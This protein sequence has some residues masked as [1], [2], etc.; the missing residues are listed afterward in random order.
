MN[1]IYKVIW[2][3]A[4][5]CFTAVGEYAK[6][7]GKSSKSS[8]SA[9]ATI[10][11]TENLSSTSAF[12][13]T[14]IGL[15]LMAAGFCIQASAIPNNGNS[16]N[17]NID[18]PFTHT[19]GLGEHTHTTNNSHKKE[20]DNSD[21]SIILEFEGDIGDP[22]ALK[23]GETLHI[24]GGETDA[25]NLSNN[26]NIG[27]VADGDILMI[28][29]AKDIDLDAD[30]SVTMGDTLVDN[31]G[32]TI[33]NTVPAKIVSLTSA[34]LNNGGNQITNVASGGLLT[35]PNN[36]HNAATIGDIVANQ[37]K[38]VSINST[39]GTNEDN[40]G[41]QGA[42]AIAIGKGASAVGQTTV[43]IGLNSGSG[44][45]AGTREG[46]SV[47][48]ASGQNV[49]S[50]GNVGIGRGAGSNIT[51]ITTSAINPFPVIKGQNVAIGADA[52][53][54]I[55]G[56][57]NSA[58]GERSGRVV[59]GNANTAI[60]SFSGNNVKGSANIAMGP[61]TGV[62]VSGDYN[63]AI[64]NFAGANVR[65]DRNVALGTEAG[66]NVSGIRNVAIGN[67]AGAG[68]TN[69]LTVA[70]GNNAGN[71]QN[72]QIGKNSISVGTNSSA[73]GHSSMALGRGSVSAGINAIGIGVQSIASATGT[74][75]VGDRAEA[76]GEN[77]IAI[78]KN[79]L[80]TGSQAIGVGSR[81]GNGGAAYGDNADAGG[82][83]MSATLTVIEGTAIG[84]GSIVNVNNGVALGSK[85]VANRTATGLGTVFVPT[86]ASGLA[87]ES[88]RSTVL[89]AV[90]VGNNADGN[91]QIVNVA[92]GRDDSDAVNVSQLR[93]LDTIV[94]GIDFPI[95]SSNAKPYTTSVTGTDALA[96][97]S[98]AIANGD[99]STAV[100]ENAK[101]IG[102]Q[103][104]AFGAGA[105]ATARSSLA[106]GFEAK[107][108]SGESVA[109]GVR[110]SAEGLGATAVGPTAN[111]RGEDSV[112]LGRRSKADGAG[113]MALGGFSEAV[114][115]NASAVGFNAEAT[116]K[117]ATAIG[118]NAKALG[119]R[120]VAI[121]EGAQATT[122]TGTA[123][124]SRTRA[125]GIQSTAVGVGSKATK[126]WSTAMGFVSEAN[127]LSSVALGDRSIVGGKESI[128]IGK[129]NTV[130]GANSIAVGTGH[131]VS[132]NNSGA[133]GDPN[134][135]SG[136]GSY[137]VGNNNAIAANN[138]FVLG[139]NV[140]IKASDKNSIALGEGAIINGEDSI[141]IGRGATAAA[142]TRNGLAIGVRSNSGNHAVSLGD[143][144]AS[145]NYAVALGSKSKASIG[146][147]AVGQASSAVSNATALGRGA[148]AGQ[149]GNVALGNGS[150]TGSQHT[151]TFAI[152]TMPV[153]GLISGARTVSVGTVGAERQIQNVAPG[154]VSATSTDAINGSQLS[155]TNS[156]IGDLG[157]TVGDGLNFTGDDTTTVINRQLGDT[158]TIK[159][160]ES[161]ASKLA[162]GNNIG[163]VANGND[164]DI[165][166]AKDLTGLNS[167]TTG[168]T[169]MN[170]SG[171]SFTGST[172]SLSGTGFTI[173]NTDPTKTVSLTNTGLNNGGFK[174]VNVGKGDV[175]ATSTDAINGSQ[176]F[177]TAQSIANNFGGGSVVNTDGTVSTPVYQINGNNQTG[178]AGAIAELDKGFSLETNGA[179]I[180][181]VKAG[182][183]VDIGTAAGETNIEVA[184]TGN[185]I[186]FKLADNIKLTSVTTG[187][188]VLNNNG[189]TIAG[190][191]SF[192]ATGINAGNQQITRV[193]SG[194]SL[195]DIN[196]QLNAAN[197]GDVKNA[198]GGVTTLGFGIKAADN[199]TVQKNLG[200]V[201][202]IIGSNSNITT[203]A[204]SGKVKVVLN[205][206]LDL[207][208]N[209]S[210]KMGNSSSLP[211]GLG[212]VTTVDRL[213][214]IT[215]NAFA[216]TSIDLTGV[217]VA[218]PLG[219][220]NL[221]ST[222]LYV[223]SG[224]SVTKAGIDAGNKKVIN[225]K[226]GSNPLDAVNYSQLETTNNAVNRG[227]DFT[228]DNTGPTS[229]ITRK[230]GQVL[231][232][233]GGN[234]NLTNLSD[235][236]IGV[237]ADNTTNTLTV[238]LA[239]DLTGLNSAAFGS[240]VMISSNGLRAGA[241]IVN[242]SGVSF[243]DSTV[244]LSS[245]G[246]NNGG[247]VITNLARGAELTD[248]VNVEQLNEVKQSAADANKGW[249]ISAQGANTSTVKP[250]D[251]VDL[252]NTDNNITVSKTA[253]SNNVSFNLSKDI[254]IDSVKTGNTTMDN[255]GLTI[256]GG[257]KFTKTS[258]DAG[259]N[260][261]TN[262]AN[263]FI[264]VASKD[265][266][267][268]GQLFEVLS[269]INTQTAAI[270]EMGS[271]LNFDADTGP[272][273]NKKAGSAPLTFKGGNNITTTSA[274]S[275]IKFDL[276][277]NINVDSVT[278]GDTTVSTNGVV[279]AGGPS[280][281]KTGIY[282]GNAET[283][284]S[285]T[286][287]GI[288]A[289]GT[290]ITNVADGMQ[291][292]DAV[293]FGQLDAVNR[294]LGNS[295]NELGYRIGEVEDDANAGISAAMAMSSLPQAYIIGKPMIGGGIATY[296]G[297]SAVAIGF[298]KMSN[299]GRWVMKLNGTADT[300][301]NVGA[302]IGAGFHFD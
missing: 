175:N 289:A 191:P 116:N 123:I 11:T 184:K 43:A 27:V 232:T 231:K 194:G 145:G 132:G 182:D 9:N 13:L 277:G 226:A 92:A 180:S 56:N 10:N 185:V 68:I 17:H 268:G 79:S 137:A 261:I 159:G 225:V 102:I 74:I 163:V 80:A 59:D 230:S 287:A 166:L 295:I 71:F 94:A 147:T 146:G 124:G 170:T 168:N 78:G 55:A 22:I 12:K 32:I 201:V 109:L 73:Q 222:G 272:V 213:G 138:S 212:P 267:N 252:N 260:K 120:S 24:L 262:V 144:S 263:G 294:N 99:R 266:V 35:D 219:I 257:P 16:S 108:K 259:G 66:K 246:L 104:S 36:Q 215:G 135:V 189:L 276:N 247:K 6:A 235:D 173:T 38:Y 271:G 160:G 254:A 62:I 292:R 181:T 53:R 269:T 84:N 3:E 42:D 126:Q 251:T 217:T 188:S 122:L 284:P 97:G 49:L 258:V 186:D 14:A 54:D 75:A 210:V 91:R 61:N 265:A 198:I 242:T 172:V 176:L 67:E 83:T 20:G 155:A 112:A 89:G 37:I 45:T 152:N 30:G 149:S 96:V 248:A 23:Q 291:P 224:P 88:T 118:V 95:R 60:G 192:T 255:S 211:L 113:A 76:S 128:A 169:V 41:A 275:S 100:G 241:T 26:D 290:K 93:A 234:T 48:N 196:N 131:I 296:N 46:V 293:N 162:S 85:S 216:N 158:L 114:G 177:G 286:A 51:S 236:N 115:E 200:E 129:G 70:I 206:N 165:K 285:M 249:N 8:V 90:S 178:V 187:N 205:N 18:Y 199:N 239:K 5:N 279:I 133:F 167:V 50:S 81:A 218:S 121:G 29:L 33:T 4:L 151:G 40:L 174:V 58:L 227:L 202:E 52:G 143:D 157:S 127:G 253:E 125:T 2:N 21:T 278:T 130:N 283:A 264:E 164:L 237:I 28:K 134:I 229:V 280:I 245:S 64:G 142:S 250:S 161:N 7:R 193:L 190:G 87:I 243:S 203:T 238:K 179:T 77:A 270:A 105:E 228:G 117:N 34:G 297:E 69:D 111:A 31:S 47:G 148:I 86:S 39:G 150:I 302:A 19:H 141:A 15:G 154:V 106:S 298:S 103:A 72:G 119:E 208:T 233:T 107:A 281:T 207:N 204:A 301:G 110:S 282:T 156:A 1:R 171:I 220:T 136:M 195:T 63:T 223:V 139:N 44:S 153:A 273:I 197:I 256:A 101:A 214:M 299:D 274:G 82:T 183:T 288:N 240:D 140:T 244:G 221:N 209:G 57:Y 65:G 300:Q 98:N 25:N